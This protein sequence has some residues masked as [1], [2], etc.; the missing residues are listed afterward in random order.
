MREPLVDDY[1]KT[2]DDS[3][4]KAQL[5]PKKR[6]PGPLMANTADEVKRI[7]DAN[8]VKKAEAKLNTTDDITKLLREFFDPN[9]IVLRL[10]LYK[11]RIN[12]SRRRGAIPLHAFYLNAPP[13]DRLAYLFDIPEP[14]HKGG[15]T[16]KSMSRSRSRSP[17]RLER[18]VKQKDK[19]KIPT[20]AEIMIKA[21]VDRH[22]DKEKEKEA[23]LRKEAELNE[24]KARG[25]LAK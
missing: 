23:S 1:A 17:Q 24:L 4:D 3:P 16:L 5:T 21:F 8:K 11:D 15:Q 7:Y 18:S 25:E 19:K 6:E 12:T 9:E 2:N 13:N 14:D 22:N 10:N 20:Q